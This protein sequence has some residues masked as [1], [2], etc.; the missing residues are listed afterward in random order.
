MNAG[1]VTRHIFLLFISA[2]AIAGFSWIDSELSI[3]GKLSVSSAY[4]SLLLFVITIG[5][6]PVDLWRNK[7]MPLS[8]Y[9]RRDLG[10][11]AALLGIFHTVA[12]LQVHLGGKFWHY[13]IYPSDQVHLVP[14][15]YDF[16]GLTN[17][18]GL[19][20][21]LVM[22]VLLMLSNN[23]SIKRMGTKKWK[24]WQRSAYLL[25]VFLPLHGVIYQ[26][27][28]NRLGSVYSLLL[29][30][31][32]LVAVSLQVSGIIKFRSNQGAKVS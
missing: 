19:L 30:V 20:S 25:V 8:S 16:F 7:K 14:I 21:T 23:R 11:W 2:S 12:G 31:M 17:H 13:F 3:A 10:I 22:I 29:G 15:R 24:N 4:I 9:L 32:A 5:M 27:L 1:R 28:E 18:L 26:V 6:G